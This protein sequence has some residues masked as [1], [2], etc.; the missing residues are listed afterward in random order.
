[1]AKMSKLPEAEH[2]AK[3]EASALEARYGGLEPELLLELVIDQYFPDQ[4]A[5]VS[6]FGT[7]SAVLLHMISEIDSGLP[8]VFLDTQKHFP[9]TIE[10]RDNLIDQLG[11]TAVTVIEPLDAELRKIDRDGKLHL[12]NTN[13]CCAVRKVEP[14]ARA[15]EPWRAW[16]TG[17]KRYQSGSRLAL[18]VFENVGP[19]IRINPLAA[20]RPTDMAAYSKVHDLPEHP[21]RQWGYLSV[22]C[23]PCTEPAKPGD[24]ERS[25]RWAGLAKT[26]CGIHL[27]GLEKSLTSSSL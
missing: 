23:M 4:V 11:L 8:V 14:M 12:T 7:G 17:R 22:G 27:S 18:P 15:I 2:E 19:R 26:E 13:A 6:S 5:S 21:L 10:Y 16:I 9:E 1:M 3:A 20:W 24:D 25:G